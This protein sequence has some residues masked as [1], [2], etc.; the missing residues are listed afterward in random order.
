MKN[1]N[2]I[3]KAPCNNASSKYGASMGRINRTTG[4]PERLHLQR[5]QFVD[6]DYDTGGAYW[7]GGTPLWCA[8]SP[9]NT[10]NDVSIQVFVRAANRQAAKNEVLKELQGTGWKF[11]R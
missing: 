5:V 3:L 8:F 11:F 6:G 4:K 1:I 7:G 2:E 10:E 9:D